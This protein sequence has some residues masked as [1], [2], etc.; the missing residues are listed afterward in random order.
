M[1]ER[2][3]GEATVVYDDPHDEDPSE[4]TVQ[5]EH[6]VYFQDHWLVRTGEDDDGR[7]TVRRIPSER[8]YYVER[9]VE[10]FEDEAATLKDQFQEEFESVASDVEDKLPT[11]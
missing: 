6:V 9:E 8:V 1:V 11:G 7:D 2:E 3:F 10:R 4:L 5:N